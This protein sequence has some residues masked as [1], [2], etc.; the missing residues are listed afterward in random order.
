MFPT[1]LGDSTITLPVLTLGGHRALFT[2]GGAD[3]VFKNGS[4]T[5]FTQTAALIFNESV[6]AAANGEV[7]PLWGTCL[8]FEL[9]RWATGI[10]QL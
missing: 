10:L 8:G 1:V 4:L 9:I 7:W 3:F 5:P 6:S 2:G